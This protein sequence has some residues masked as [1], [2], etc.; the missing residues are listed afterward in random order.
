MYCYGRRS[1]RFLLVYYGFCFEKNTYD[2]LSCR[3]W[4]S[5]DKE[6][7][8]DQDKLVNALMFTDKDLEENFKEK[9][10]SV[11]KQIKFKSE[12]LE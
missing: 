5:I 4:R 6:A 8:L 1:N 11:S 7:K 12:S 9:L 2:S 3:I 10:N